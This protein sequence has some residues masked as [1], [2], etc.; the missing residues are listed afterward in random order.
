M[1]VFLLENNNRYCF[2]WVSKVGVRYAPAQVQVPIVPSKITP[3]QPPL[4][5]TWTGRKFFNIYTCWIGST[6][7]SIHR[8]EIASPFISFELAPLFS[9]RVDFSDGLR[10]WSIGYDV[11]SIRNLAM[12]C[13][14]IY[15]CIKSLCF[16][17]AAKMWSLPNDRTC[18]SS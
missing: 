10:L 12:L 2:F 18:R 16:L 6:R 17:F 5:A 7:W 11:S 4:P 8:I 9:E 3:M 1:K 13:S 15:K 14:C